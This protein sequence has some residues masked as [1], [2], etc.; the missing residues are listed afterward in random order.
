MFTCAKA[1][2][3][4]ILAQL[5]NMISALPRGHARCFVTPI[6]RSSSSAPVPSAFAAL[7]LQRRGGRV[8]VVDRNQRTTQRSYALAIHPRTLRI[9]DQAGLSERLIAAVRKVTRPVYYEGRER[10]AGIDYSALTSKHP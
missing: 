9:L 4:A 6:L 5:A 10:R 3:E 7:F 1:P 2:I 8:E